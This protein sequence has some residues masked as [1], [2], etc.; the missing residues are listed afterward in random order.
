MRRS[1]ASAVVVLLLGA[2]ALA[3]CQGTPTVY[4]VCLVRP[5][6]GPVV[7]RGN[8]TG[9]IPDLRGSRVRLDEW[10]DYAGST[11]WGVHRSSDTVAS[12]WFVFA[13][14]LDPSSCG[15]G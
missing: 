2:G 3:G 4:D 13:S 6:G 8:G 1:A 11:I 7:L 9:K 10:R 14:D 5:N 15:P 12:A